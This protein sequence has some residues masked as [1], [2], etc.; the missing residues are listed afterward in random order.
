M[1]AEMW[2]LIAFVSFLALCGKKIWARIIQRLDYH[3]ATVKKTLEDAEQAKV[4]ADIALRE[5]SQRKKEI[6]Q[7]IEEQKSLS[8][9]RLDDMRSKHH[10]TVEFLRNR[11]QRDMHQQM[12]L[13][14]EEHKRK[15]L[16][17]A[18]HVI[19]QSILQHVREQN[20]TIKEDVLFQEIQKAF[21]E[22]S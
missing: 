21:S 13:N 4:A 5:I 1:P 15:I 17:I 14:L 3:I 12:Q 9:M 16:V 18:T 10:D 11:Y 22:A 19:K 6:D 8:K 2:L 20:I 7:M